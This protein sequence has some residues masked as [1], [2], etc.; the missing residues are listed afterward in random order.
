MISNF[1]KKIFGS[2]NGR[3]LKEYAPLVKK[4]NELDEWGVA[5]PPGRL[6]GKRFGVRGLGSRLGA[7]VRVR[8]RAGLRSGL[9]PRPPG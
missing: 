2:R 3:I 6:T 1:I 8:V 5:P 7:R 9:S 4:V